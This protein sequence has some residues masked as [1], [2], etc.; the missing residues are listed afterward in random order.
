MSP[1][2]DSFVERLAA[3]LTQGLVV[4]LGSDDEVS[5]GRRA[6]SH[7]ENVMFVAASPENIPW[8]DGFFT[9]VLDPAGLCVDSP[10]VAMEMARVLASNDG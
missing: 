1:P 8:Q 3:R 6:Y 2:W 5:Q 9:R 7:L 4:V 10:K